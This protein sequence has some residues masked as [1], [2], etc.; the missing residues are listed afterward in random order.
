MITIGDVKKLAGQGLLYI[1]MKQVLQCIVDE[2]FQE[3]S[4]SFPEIPPLLSPIHLE[5]LE[6]KTPTVER[7]A[8]TTSATQ[9]P[10]FCL[11]VINKI[12]PNITGPT[13]MLK[14]LQKIG[15]PGRDLDVRIMN[16]CAVFRELRCRY[17]SLGDL[18]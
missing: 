11:T 2:E 14:H 17:T 1:G 3:D 13:E 4:D 16:I 12:P 18:T 7:V 9:Q 15:L 5:I 8:P 6:P 10:S